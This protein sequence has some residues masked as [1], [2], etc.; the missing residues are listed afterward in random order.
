[1]AFFNCGAIFSTLFRYKNIVIG[2][3]KP[4]LEGVEKCH[5]DPPAKQSQILEN[6][7]AI[8]RILWVFFFF[9]L[10]IGVN[11]MNCVNGVAGVDNN[12]DN[13][14]M[15]TGARQ[16]QSSALLRIASPAPSYSPA[17]PLPFSRT[18]SLRLGSR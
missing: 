17:P 4:V 6:K 9:V 5:C 13:D 12:Q 2:F 18:K 11:S 3:R 16:G 8:F 14:H 15:E 10:F 1:M 7:I